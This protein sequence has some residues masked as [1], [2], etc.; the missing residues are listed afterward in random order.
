MKP[1]LLIE[2]YMSKAPYSIGADQ[3]IAKA[4]MAM[5]ELRIRHLPVLSGG[6]IIGIVSDRDIKFIKGFK[7]VN[8]ETTKISEA[9]VE[10]IY[11]V[12]PRTPFAEVCAEMAL[13][14]YESVLVIDGQK[15]VGIFTW[16][17]ALRA[18]SEIIELSD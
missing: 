13:Y 4:E 16:V 6:E 11:T 5:R 18:F 2:K 15:L 14:K 9:C 17:D 1:I 10:Q 7:G 8:T 3:P 12:T